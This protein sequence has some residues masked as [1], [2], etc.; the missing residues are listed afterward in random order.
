M[1]LSRTTDYI[2]FIIALAISMVSC[3]SGEHVA[4]GP[5]IMTR[6]DLLAIYER[7]GFDEVVIV[8]PKG[9][10]VAHYVLVDREDTADFALPEGALEIKVPLEGAIVD[11][12]V[13]T[14]ALEELGAVDIVKGLLDA[15]FATSPEMQKRLQAKSTIDVGASATPNIEKIVTLQPDAMIISYYDGMQ[16]QGVDKLDIPV[17]KMLDLQEEDP[18]GRAEWIR[19]IG[20][21]AGKPA[22]ADSI[23]QKVKEEYEEIS[24]GVSV[25]ESEK[26][27]ILT[28]LIYEGVWY[29]PGGRSYQARLIEDAGG[30][31]FKADNEQYVTLN[32]SAEQVLA[33]GGDADVWIIKHFG[34]ESELKSI[35]DADPVYR[36]IKAYKEGNIYFSDTSKSSLFR[37]F[38]FHPERL[39]K[40]YR[41]IINGDSIGEGRYFRKL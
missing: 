20:R 30:R 12:E 11:S 23:F 7:D 32:L 26:P 16:V 22:E 39:L 4:H 35:L 31:Y 33:E 37:E 9:K 8:N 38:P 27:K 28:D 36:E 21:L 15:A 13:Y 29:V 19:L 1:R 3:T 14:S 2:L 24:G 34:D 17:I 41:I 18:L 25:E 5:N 6:S 10:Q 40:D